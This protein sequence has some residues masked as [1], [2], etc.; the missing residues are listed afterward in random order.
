MGGRST[1][2]DHRISPGGT[3]KPLSFLLQ[4]RPPKHLG[5]VQQ[6]H[7]LNSSYTRHS[8]CPPFPSPK[9]LRLWQGFEHSASRVQGPDICLN[10]CFRVPVTLSLSAES[11]VYLSWRMRKSNSC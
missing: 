4:D 3:V 1:R 9:I 8:G 11:H 10:Q 7:M 2:D 5:S 6:I